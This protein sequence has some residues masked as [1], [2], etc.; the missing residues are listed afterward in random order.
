MRSLTIAHTCWQFGQA[1]FLRTICS[2]IGLPWMVIKMNHFQLEGLTSTI[3]VLKDFTERIPAPGPLHFQTEF[4]VMIQICEDSEIMWDNVANFSCNC[5]LLKPKSVILKTLG[6]KN[7][8]I[9]GIGIFLF[10]LILNE[11]ILER[12]YHVQSLLPFFLVW[13]DIFVLFCDWYQWSQ[14]RFCKTWNRPISF[15]VIFTIS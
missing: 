6:P 14:V 1:Y 7:Q 13:W 8:I 11:Q 12:N 3:I 5:I 10:S 9:F 15:T 4:W 2:G